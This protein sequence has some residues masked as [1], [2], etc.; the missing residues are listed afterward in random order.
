MEYKDLQS[1]SSNGI[2]FDFMDRLEHQQIFKKEDMRF[3]GN[4]EI[5]EEINGRV[6]IVTN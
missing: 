1:G 6:V 3:F 4:I 5:L 2:S